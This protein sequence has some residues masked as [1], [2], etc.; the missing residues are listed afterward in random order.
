M[1]LLKTQESNTKY[2]MKTNF[3]DGQPFSKEL[4]AVQMGKSE[5]KRNELVH[6]GQAMLDFTLIYESHYNY[7]HPTDESKVG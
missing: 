2:V 1:K 5:I 4:L 7:I 3:K 6:L